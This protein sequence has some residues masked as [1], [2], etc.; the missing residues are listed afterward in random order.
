VHERSHRFELV[1]HAGE[2]HTLIAKGNASVG[3]SLERF[4]YFN[5]ELARM[6]DMHAHPKRM[7]FRQNRA[8]LW[9]NALGQENRNARSDAKK[10]NVLYRAQ[11]AEQL[12]ELVVAKNERV[13]A[14]EQDIAHF[15]V[16]FEIPERFLEIR[17]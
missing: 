9:R 12:V 11:P 3:E 4:F 5:R 17:M 15:G 16:L 2:Q 10:F 6:V 13:A 1:I 14:T 7:M 8:Q